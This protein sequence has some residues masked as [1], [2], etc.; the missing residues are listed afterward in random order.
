MLGT[1]SE[2]NAAASGAEEQVGAAPHEGEGPAPAL[3]QQQQQQHQKPRTLPLQQIDQADG[4]PKAGPSVIAAAADEA[5]GESAVLKLKGLPFST[6]EAAIREFFAG[7]TVGALCFWRASSVVDLELRSSTLWPYVARGLARLQLH[8][9]AQT[10]CVH[11][12]RRLRTRELRWTDRRPRLRCV[13]P[14]G[15]FRLRARWPAKRAGAFG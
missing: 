12:V 3:E 4:P 9:S 1:A 6:S 5:S 10:H 2:P 11:C 13:G 7:F 8:G 14:R 15:S